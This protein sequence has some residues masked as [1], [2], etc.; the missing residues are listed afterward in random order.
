MNRH[1]KINFP[2]LYNVIRT[3]VI[4]GAV[5]FASLVSS[6]GSDEP[7]PQPPEPP[8]PPTVIKID[9]VRY[10]D[11]ADVA[12]F[13]YRI[14]TMDA[15]SQKENTVVFIGFA[16]SANLIVSQ[17]DFPVLFTLDAILKR[18]N[19][20]FTPNG[21]I[22]TPAQ[23]KIVLADQQCDVVASLWNQ[24]LKFGTDGNG[25]RFYI[26]SA[27]K[28]KFSDE[29][30]SCLGYTDARQIVITKGSELAA[31]CAEAEMLAQREKVS[32]EFRGDINLDAD[33]LPEF[34]KILRNNNIAVFN[35]DAAITVT[36]T[37][38]LVTPHQTASLWGWQG[39]PV[40]LVV[41]KNTKAMGNMDPVIGGDS[42]FYLM[43]TAATAE[44]QPG[45]YAIDI[46]DEDGNLINPVV[47]TYSPSSKLYPDK[48]YDGS[49]AVPLD[50]TRLYY[51]CFNK[52]NGS[53]IILRE[54]GAI[55]NGGY[56]KYN[57]IPHISNVNVELWYSE[58]PK[59]MNEFTY[60]FNYWNGGFSA[61]KALCTAV[62]YGDIV[63]AITTAGLGASDY[64]ITIMND[65]IK[66]CF[67]SDRML[68]EAMSEEKRQPGIIRNLA[69]IRCYLSDPTNLVTFALWTG[70]NFDFKNQPVQWL[71]R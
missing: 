50:I 63:H 70:G 57:L 59:F 30:Q 21:A 53:L 3:G 24:G 2:G 65:N 64:K 66:I 25:C 38:S 27:Q 28:D 58:D 37:G 41:K 55:V 20:R 26:S 40:K 54:S 29:M 31:K 49:P 69:N 17:T 61:N 56:V 68:A 4:S 7:T 10:E 71:Q 39:K 62:N 23:D 19:V 9:T 51:G 11:M 45:N 12:G 42:V 36:T 46:V 13:K 32:V 47:G 35:A 33:K 16:K 43:R 67:V 18:S 1:W 52:E 22:L 6:C 14:S 48:A 5:V 60:S 44:K 15:N 8:E 34:R